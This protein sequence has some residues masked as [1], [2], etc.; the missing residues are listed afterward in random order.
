LASAEVE[1]AKETGDGLIS[2]DLNLSVQL[3]PETHD[4][5]GTLAIDDDWKFYVEQP[6]GY[7]GLEPCRW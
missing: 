2:R 7:S 5:P 4:P 6:H 1:S 3:F